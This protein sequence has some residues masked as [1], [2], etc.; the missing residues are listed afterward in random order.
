MSFLQLF[1]DEPS[2]NRSKTI[3]ICAMLVLAN[4]LAWT[5]ALVELADRPALFATAFLAYT[6]GFRPG[7]DAHTIAAI[8]NVVRKL[9]Q[10][11]KRPVSVGFFFSLGHSTVVVVAAI[12][13]AATPTALQSRFATFKAFGG[14]IGSSVSVFFLLTIAV[15]NLM[16]LSRVGGRFPH[17]RRG[18]RIELDQDRKS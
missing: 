15:V 10:E 12:G 14:I 11:G 1:N 17:V 3:A 9:M 7:V 13:I 5:W 8:D 6:L 18:G 2:Q 16:I 4:A